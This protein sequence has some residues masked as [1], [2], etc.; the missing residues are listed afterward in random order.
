MMERELREALLAI[1]I[2]ATAGLAC[3]QGS[4]SDHEKPKAEPAKSQPASEPGA[5]DEPKPAAPPAPSN[6][7]VAAADRAKFEVTATLPPIPTTKSNPPVGTEWNEGVPINTQGANARG[8]NCR[9]LLLRE[10]LNIHCNGD[11][12]GYEK[13]EDFGQL[14]E[15]YYEQIVP[16]KLASFVIRLRPGHSPKIRICRQQNRA[17]LFVSWPPSKDFPTH[18]ALGHGP[19]CDGSDWGV[20]Y[21]NKGSAAAK[22]QPGSVPADEEAAYEAMDAEILQQAKKMCASGVTDACNYVCGKTSCP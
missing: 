17:S 20:G 9:M 14:H 13:K 15:D 5:T 16:G 1:A 6:P 7:A 21:G 10:W 19:P 8:K 11:V 3:K 22:A 2:C 12:I 4:G 18:V